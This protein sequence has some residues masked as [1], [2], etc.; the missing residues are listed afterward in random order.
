MDPPEPEAKAEGPPTKSPIPLFWPGEEAAEETR[1]RVKGLIPEVG[2][3][4]LAARRGT[5]KTFM[6]KEDDADL[7]LYLDGEHGKGAMVV[8]KVRDGIDSILIEYECVVV[9][10]GLDR[11]GDPV[12]TC[13]VVLRRPEASEAGGDDLKMTSS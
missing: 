2:I 5:G 12:T 4:I 8:E 13:Q 9:E 1:W 10:L 6:A 11:D 7:V 3:G